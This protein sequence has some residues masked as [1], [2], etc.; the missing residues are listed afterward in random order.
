MKFFDVVTLKYNKKTMAAAARQ[1]AV[2]KLWLKY[3]LRI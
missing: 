2:T 1:W 3:L